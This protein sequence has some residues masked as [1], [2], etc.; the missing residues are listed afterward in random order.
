MWSPHNHGATPGPAMNPDA[1]RH[2]SAAG[3]LVDIDFDPPNMTTFHPPQ[4][5]DRSAATMVSEVGS[6]NNELFSATTREKTAGGLLPVNTF[7]KENGILSAGPA[8][9]VYRPLG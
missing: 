5:E 1:A 6:N 7:G 3:V 2:S 4:S 8:T 9:R